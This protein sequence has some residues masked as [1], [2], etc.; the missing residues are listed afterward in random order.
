M[1]AATDKALCTTLGQGHR[2]S[3]DGSARRIQALSLRSCEA[4][5]IA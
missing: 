5:S 1:T 3:V 2:P 4:C